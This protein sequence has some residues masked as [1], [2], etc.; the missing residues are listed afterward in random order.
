MP[1]GGAE[2]RAGQLAT[3][4]GI[5]HEKTTDSSSG[6]WLDQLEDCPEAHFNAYEW[7]NIREARREYDRETKVPKELVQEIAEL[8]SKGHQI[9]V[10]ARKDNKFSDFTGVLTRLI[11]LKKQWAH[12]INPDQHPYDVNMD[13]YERGFSMAQADPLFA[14]LKR[15]SDLDGSFH[16]PDRHLAQANQR[17][18]VRRF[19]HGAL[20]AP[21]SHT[22]KQHD[23][24][25]HDR[26]SRHGR[27]P[28]GTQDGIEAH[29]TAS[30]VS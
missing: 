22:C 23:A 14:R 3:L 17:F 5:I 18:H 28:H 7:C 12:H 9:W 6:K 26:G 1:P 15:S 11:E 19:Y 24:P 30:D 20:A 10:Q 13:V 21:E 27:H 8:G 25:Q 29:C 2:S 16:G 4:A